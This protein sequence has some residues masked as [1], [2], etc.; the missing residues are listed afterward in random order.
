MNHYKT[1]TGDWVSKQTIDFRIRDAK[2]EKLAAQLNEYGYHF[3]ENENCKGGCGWL[4]CSHIISVDDCQKSG[5]AELAWDVKNLEILC[6]DCHNEHHLR[7]A[8]K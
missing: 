3:C 8:N 5:R 1:S 7:K 6:R 4:D 2:K